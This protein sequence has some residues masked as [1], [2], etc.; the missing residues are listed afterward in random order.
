MGPARIGRDYI[1]PEEVDSPKSGISEIEV[2]YDGGSSD[3]D[4][5]FHWSA[6]TF[7]WYGDKALG[8]RWNGYR[9]KEVGNPQSR[10]RPTW[11]I[12]PDELTEVI[13]NEIKMKKGH[14][15][16]RKIGEAL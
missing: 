11:F 3:P 15:E 7:N 6:A 2:L 12:I 13:I 4:E 9:G 1:P 10:G 8:I 5:E 16:R 14:W